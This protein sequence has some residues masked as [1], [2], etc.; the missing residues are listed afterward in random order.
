[1]ALELLMRPKELRL[2][3]SHDPTALILPLKRSTA[4][5]TPGE[6]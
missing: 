3:A 4:H 1:M 2:E 6:R 5:E